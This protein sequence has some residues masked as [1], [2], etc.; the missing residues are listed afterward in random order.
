MSTQKEFKV[1]IQLC[2]ENPLGIAGGLAQVWNDLVDITME[3]A[4]QEMLNMN[5]EDMESRS[6]MRISL[7]HAPSIFQERLTTIK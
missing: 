3:L 2:F 7:I 5:C 6:R 4:S 1:P